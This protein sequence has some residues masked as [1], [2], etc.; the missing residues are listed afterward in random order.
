MFQRKIKNRVH[1]VEKLIYRSLSGKRLGLIIHNHLNPQIN[2]CW[3]TE[4]GAFNYK[5][6]IER[7][8]VREK[9]CLRFC[10]PLKISGVG[11]LAACLIRGI[12]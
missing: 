10:K 3:G 12:T 2:L 6:C 5:E 7:S 9:H 4:T 11:G 1:I 8:F